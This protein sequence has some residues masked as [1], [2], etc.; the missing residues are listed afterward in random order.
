[1]RRIGEEEGK[2]MRGGLGAEVEGRRT[3]KK[4]GRKRG[5]GEEEGRR[6]ERK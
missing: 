6:K 5:A 3:Q 1:M 2:E 4:D